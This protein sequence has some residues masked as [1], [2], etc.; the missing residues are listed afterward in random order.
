MNGYLCFGMI[1]VLGDLCF[2]MVCVLGWFV[3]WMICIWGDL[4]LG[5]GLQKKQNDSILWQSVS[6]KYGLLFGGNGRML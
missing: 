3:F 5:W 6:R 2:G 4:Y 1:C